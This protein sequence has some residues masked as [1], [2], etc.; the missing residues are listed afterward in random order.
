M[1]ARAAH[2]GEKADE[3]RRLVLSRRDAVS[4][5]RTPETGFAIMWASAKQNVRKMSRMSFKGAAASSLV[6]LS[7]MS[8]VRSGT[9]S[10]HIPD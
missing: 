4:T 1:Q 6:G 3:E 8:S 9:F 2:G 7:A 5:S 10:S